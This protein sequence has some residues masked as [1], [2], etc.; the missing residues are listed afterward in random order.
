MTD[1]ELL[2]YLTESLDPAKRLAI[3]SSLRADPTLA[4]RLSR[5]RRAIELLESDATPQPPDR[6]A[7]RTAARLAML[8]DAAAPVPATEPLAHPARP[9]PRAP[10]DEPETRVVGGRFRPDLI[11]ACGIAVLA[12]GLIFSGIGKVRARNEVYACQNALR[13]T[14][15]GLAGYADTHN[16]RYPQIG[17]ESTADSFAAALTASGQVPANF[18]AACPACPP[19]TAISEP[20]GAVGYTYTLGYRGPTGDLVG[21][22]RPSTGSDEHDLVPIAADY[23]AAN[24]APGT[25]PLC[26]HNLGMNVLFAGGNVRLATSPLIGPDRDHIFQDIYGHVGAGW[27]PNDVVLG[28]PGDRP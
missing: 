9:L 10:R 22:R 5:F 14:H 2:D 27:G 28:R 18:R 16:G 26:P 7:E 6:L 8:L 19:G 23:P 24:A 15:V 13:V 17:R 21:L 20:P 25:G 1:A 4:S 12:G 11:V 3:E